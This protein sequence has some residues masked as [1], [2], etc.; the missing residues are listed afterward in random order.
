MNSEISDF[1]QHI[2]VQGRHTIYIYDHGHKYNPIA[3]RL[4][5]LSLTR[6]LLT[7]LFG[8]DDI[9]DVPFN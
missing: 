2:Y 1:F 9:R 3:G 7:D 4:C 5:G 6:N 8:F